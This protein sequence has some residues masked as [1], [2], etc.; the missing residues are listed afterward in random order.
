MIDLEALSL[1]E[2]IRL[3][4]AL[5]ESITRKFQ[6]Q[7]ALVFSDIV[8]STSYF[9]RFGNEAGRSLQQR[10]IDQLQSVLPEHQGR[11]VDTAGDGAFLC[12][13]R[14]EAA[15]NAMIEL[16]RR[17]SA[18][19][20]NR[21]N[22]HQLSVR[23]GVHWGSVLTDAQIVTGDAVN[24]CSRVAASCRPGEIRVTRPAFSELPSS[25]R[26]R[27]RALDPVE[28]KGVEQKVALLELVWWDPARFPD[29][30]KIEN[31]GEQ[32]PL[33]LLDTISFGRVSELDGVKANDVVLKLPDERL[34]NLISRWHFE[35]RRRSS[36]FVLCP[37]SSQVTEVD[38]RVLSRGEEVE[39]RA[40]TIVRL[41][42]TI[43]LKFGSTYR[44]AVDVNATVPVPG[45]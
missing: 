35:L 21:S 41:A 22:E 9:T 23:I 14:A 5:S 37:V 2:S 19:N 29:Y 42:K 45:S 8:G 38:G 30:V 36:G 7:L 15:C 40:G 28:L 24:L 17:I 3:Q 43:V 26:L 13:P 10:H 32:L 6:R 33:P 4:S 39:I 27:C 18:D 11:I 20:G 12:F 25:L 16:E 34:N 31:S 1:T 44:A